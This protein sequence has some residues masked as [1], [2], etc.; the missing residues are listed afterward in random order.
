[1]SLQLVP[2]ACALLATKAL[3]NL[4][5]ILDAGQMTLRD[6]VK[7]N[8]YIADMNDYEAMN[9]IYAEFFTEK[10]PARVTIR[11]AE[12]PGLKR[13]DGTANGRWLLENLNLEAEGSQAPPFEDLPGQVRAKI[14]DGIATVAMVSPD[15]EKTTS[16]ASV[17]KI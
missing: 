10:Y 4:A 2:L 14:K 16:V 9:R 3:T 12:I 7:V 13:L 15:G 11:A 6:V 1:M 8:V 17:K 5:N